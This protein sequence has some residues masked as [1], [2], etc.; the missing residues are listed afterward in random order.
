MRG[1]LRAMPLDGLGVAVPETV[2]RFVSSMFTRS[3]NFLE[4]TVFLGATPAKIENSRGVSHRVPGALCFIPE[5]SLLL[6]SATLFVPFQIRG[7]VADA[8]QASRRC[9]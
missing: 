8:D 3:R 5:N 7:A 9:G 1:Y 4:A 2:R 6:H